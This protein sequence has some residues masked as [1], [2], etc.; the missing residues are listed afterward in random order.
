[1]SAIIPGSTEN[2]TEARANP[3]QGRNPR[4]QP[5][6]RC[7]APALPEPIDALDV[8]DRINDIGVHW[9]SIIDSIL[10]AHKRA[11]LGL[12]GAPERLPE[13]AADRLAD[14]GRHDYNYDE[15]TDKVRLLKDWLH[16][17]AGDG[18]QYRYEVW[19]SRG[20]RLSFRHESWADAAKVLDELK[21]RHPEAF[22][23]RLHVMAAGHAYGR[24]LE[25]EM[26]ETLIGRI[27]HVGTFYGDDEEEYT[28]QDE[29]GRQVSVLATTLRQH[30]I[31][32][33]LD[34]R[35]KESL[36]HYLK[37]DKPRKDAIRKA[38]AERDAGAAP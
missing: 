38:A 29:T 31:Y 10:G 14:M 28:V 25:P 35:G 13:W 2:T 17:A 23:A 32:E 26:L 6:M 19:T 3:K 8:L 20:A 24:G 36:D 21:P 15:H 34:K 18:S 37:E 22:I 30:P 1:M 27:S 7:A 4:P 33:R 11:L 16:M 5:P 9:W 12:E